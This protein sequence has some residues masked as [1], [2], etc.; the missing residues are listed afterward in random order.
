M[1]SWRLAAALAL[2]AA[3][4]SGLAQDFPSQPIRMIVPAGA[5]GGADVFGRLFAAK[6]GEFLGQ[7]IVV[8]NVPGAGGVVGA[9][10]VAKA[11]ADGHTILFGIG[12]LF[13]MIPALTPKLPYGPKDLTPVTM[14]TRVAYL[15][16]VNASFP[17]RTMAELIEHAR[18]NPDKVSYA[19]TGVGSAAHLG[20]ELLALEAKV[21]ML[22]V[23]F[24]NTGIPEVIGGQVHMKLEPVGSAVP[25][26]KGGRLRALAVSS[27]RRM[28]TLPDVPAIAETLPGF[29]L[30]GWHGIAV[31]AATPA[32]AVARLRDAFV[33]TV[34]DVGIRQKITEVGAEPVGS[35][36]EEMAGIIERELRTWTNLIRQKGIKAE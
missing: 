34:Q 4:S 14:T 3:C 30:T 12:P 28:A 1:A 23:P 5:G 32:P 6:A 2:S 19:S 7:T 27:A 22:H 26:V 21:S 29:E 11:R 17:A 31:P 36:A 20:G 24:K 8:E 9:D 25:L 16:L 18:A 15:L 33:R 10:R 13:T 35:T